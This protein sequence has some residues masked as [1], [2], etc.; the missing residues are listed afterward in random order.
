MITTIRFR[1]E[2]GKLVARSQSD[3][4]KWEQFK[5][6]VDNGVLVEGFFEVLQDDA[7][8]GQLAKVHKIIREVAAHTGHSFDDVKLLVKKRS[9]LCLVK[10]LDGDIYLECRSFGDCSYEELSLAIQVAMEIGE[11]SGIPVL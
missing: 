5:K 2:D 1:K 4:K 7:T 10:Q 11:C 9:G 3:K 8:L 6:Q